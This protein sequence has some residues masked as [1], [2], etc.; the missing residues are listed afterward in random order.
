[1]NILGFVYTS[2]GKYSFCSIKIKVK[3]ISIIKNKEVFTI[4][5]LF[6]YLNN[7][8][9]TLGTLIVIF[10]NGETK[11]NGQMRHNNHFFKLHFTFFCL[12]FL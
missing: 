7:D 2:L 4:L 3:K 6:T 12:K 8:Q 1:M 9:C 11:S 5:L 10:G